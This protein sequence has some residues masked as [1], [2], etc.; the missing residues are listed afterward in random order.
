M[1]RSENNKSN[2]RGAVETQYISADLPAHLTRLVNPKVLEQ[3]LEKIREDA[4]N[5]S[6][7]AAR[8]RRYLETIVNHHLGKELKGA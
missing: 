5:T 4:A 8:R 7:E 3:R 6:V 2:R 1:G